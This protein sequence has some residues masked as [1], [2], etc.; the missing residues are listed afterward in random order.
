MV[1]FNKIKELEELML[2]WRKNR[3]DLEEA[4]EGEVTE[5]TGEWEGSFHTLTGCIRD[6][7]SILDL[8]IKNLGK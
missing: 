1:E 6:V 4:L 2:K 7:E 3:K 5:F 8:T